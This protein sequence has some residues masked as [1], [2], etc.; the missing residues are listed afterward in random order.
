MS[1]EFNPDLLVFQILKQH[2]HLKKSD[3][4]TVASVKVSLARE[5][6]SA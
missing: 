6:G 2:Q 3:T 1:E 4:F 5:V